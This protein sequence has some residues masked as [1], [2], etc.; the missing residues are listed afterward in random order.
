[1]F[2]SQTQDGDGIYLIFFMVTQQKEDR[3]VAAE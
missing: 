2:L 1:M 3:E